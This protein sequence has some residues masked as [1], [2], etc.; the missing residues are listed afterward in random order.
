M[1]DTKISALP[2]VTIPS[3]TDEFP[4]NQGGVSKKATRPFMRM[5]LYAFGSVTI[6]TNTYLLHVKTLELT[7]TQRLTIEGTGRLSII[8]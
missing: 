7:S 1:P 4:L 3:P 5:G 2:A 8:T 6:P